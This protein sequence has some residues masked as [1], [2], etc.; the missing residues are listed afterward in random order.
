[1]ADFDF[2]SFRPLE[3]DVRIGV[4]TE[5]AKDFS[6]IDFSKLTF[7]AKGDSAVIKGEIHY[8]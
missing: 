4:P 1:M 8:G 5:M 2:D 6:K 3:P 7:A